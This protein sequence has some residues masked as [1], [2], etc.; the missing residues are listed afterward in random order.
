M[1]NKQ[2]SSGYLKFISENPHLLAF[3]FALTF[4][5]SLG[6]TFF[7]GTFGPS[8]LK[9]FELSHTAWGSIYMTGT[10][11]SALCL[12]LTGQLIDRFP[13]KIYTLIVIS[14][15]CIS[16][17][18]ISFN[19]SFWLLIPIIFCLRHTGQ[20]L[21]SHVAITTMARHFSTGRG[22]AVAL[23][24]L[25][26][27]FGESFLPLI[28]VIAIGVLGWRTTYG[29]TSILLGIGIIPL[30]LWLLR[31]SFLGQQANSNGTY[32]VEKTLT[33]TM[34]SWT[35]REMLSDWRFY[36]LL[37]AVVAPS[38][39][40]T[41][42]FF[43][44]LTLA[45]AKNWSAVWFTG[46]YWVYAVGSMTASLTFGPV[47]DR[48]TAIKSVPFFLMPKICALIIIWAFN[49]PIWA[50]PYLLLLGLNVGMT[51]TGLTSLWAELYGPK[52]LGAIRSL[53]VAITVLASALGPP[54]M[55]FMIDTN[56][57]M[58]NIC[59]IF[60]IYCVIATIFIFAGLRSSETS[61]KRYSGS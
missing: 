22:K 9:E 47:I 37:P 34:K 59:I 52:H 7:I 1:N 24:S 16:G 46:S 61:V 13:L 36:L 25:G 35:R 56:I 51:Y 31:K 21:T 8:I 28:I 53:I 49:D 19:P 11:M 14:G 45:E 10:I 12:P 48:M 55:G 27:A 15:L 58:G 57:S 4:A 18:F 2:G 40:G 32:I 5:S 60:A 39:I 29:L 43:H 42:L 6:Q 17:L 20:G 33:T 50:W 54:V 38:F 41:A 23:A 44:H 26:Y 30:T 3:G